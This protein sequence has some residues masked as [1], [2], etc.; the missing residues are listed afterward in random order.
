MINNQDEIEKK[1]DSI[2]EKLIQAFQPSLNEEKIKEFSIE[3]LNLACEM[4]EYFNNRNLLSSWIK[5][6]I[7]EVTKLINWNWLYAAVNELRLANCS[8][9]EISPNIKYR[10]EIIT[11]DANEIINHID[12]F[13]KIIKVN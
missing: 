9:N 13:S 1:L 8:P 11:L 4:V 2:Q 5:D 3:I 12:G 10:E 6:H 7:V